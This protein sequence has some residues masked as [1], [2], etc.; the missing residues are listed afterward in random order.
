M[1]FYLEMFNGNHCKIEDYYR[2]EKASKD[3]YSLLD[4]DRETDITSFADLVSQYDEMISNSIRSK[5]K[6]KSNHEIKII[7]K[8]Y[9]DELLKNILID[10]NEHN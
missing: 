1:G 7:I 6:N 4:K 3:L 10:I 9:I 8:N 5:V 2:L